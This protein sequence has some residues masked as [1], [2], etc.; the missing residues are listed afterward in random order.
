MKRCEIESVNPHSGEKIRAY[1]P[2]NNEQVNNLL[3]AAVKT[4]QDW[5]KS[6]FP[7][8][9]KLTLLSAGISMKGKTNWP[10]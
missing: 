6:S 3:Q 7:E 5:R 2:Y 1:S 9:A 10:N 8:R 4:Y